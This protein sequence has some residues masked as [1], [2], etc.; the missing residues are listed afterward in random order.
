MTPAPSTTP[1]PAILYAL[2]KDQ[3]ARSLGDF[4]IKA[5]EEALSKRS[6]FT[7]AVSGGSLAN[8]LVEGLTSRAEVKW[9]K[10]VVFFADER[11]V[12]L[13]HEDSNYRI[14][15]EG[16]FSKVPIPTQ[17]IHP[18]ST[19][20]LDDPEEV[21]H[22]Y[23]KQLMNEFAGKFLTHPFFCFS[24]G[25]LIGKNAVAFPRFDL[26]LLG[27]GPDG[28]TCSLFPGH[29]LLKEDSTWVSWLN[30]SPKPP[31]TRITLTYPVLNHAHKVAFVAIGEGKKD[32]IQKLLDHPELG[33]PSS[34]VKPIPPGQVYWSVCR[35][36]RSFPDSIHKERLQAL[37]YSTPPLPHKDSKRGCRKSQNN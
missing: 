6:K 22:E 33:L 1:H 24:G 3:V 36:G 4:V 9:D 32:I 15:H 26:I 2:P 25:G 8:T 19:E 31:S 10:W 35:R 29:D 34:L 16:L 30:D 28:H 27:A 21:A 37:N 12:P 13:D 14:V 7:L 11:V 18:I 23:E 17:N 5:Q 20:N